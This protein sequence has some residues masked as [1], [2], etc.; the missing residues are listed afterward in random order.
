M[1]SGTMTN[2]VDRLAAR[3]LV[4]R[5][6]DPRDRRGVLVRLTPA[7][8]T[9]RRR[10]ARGAAE[11]GAR[12]AR[13]ARRG[14]AAP[15]RRPAARARR[16]VRGQTRAVSEIWLR[17]LSGRTSTRSA[18]PAPRS[19]ARSSRSSP[20]TAAARRSSSR[21]STWCRTTAGVGHFNVLRGHVSTLG[22]ARGQRHQ[23][24][25]R[26]RAE[27]PSTGLPSELGLADALRPA[28]RRTPLRSWT[29]P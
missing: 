17:F 3:G 8:R 14:R 13:R 25:R 19:S 4:E 6:P 28:H 9:R 10:R 29:R 23:G 1:T 22:R 7:G 16:A 27:L 20:R 24:G 18:S 26:L 12:P 15:A 21:G 11:P 5:L 2:R